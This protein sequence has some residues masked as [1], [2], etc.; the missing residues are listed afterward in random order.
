MR[1]TKTFIIQLL[2]VAAAVVFAGVTIPCFAQD[3]GEARVKQNDRDYETRSNV[4][5]TV[6]ESNPKPKTP[7]PPTPAEVMAQARDDYMGLQI[8]N[9]S[10]KQALASTNPL[11]LQ[12]ISSAVAEV[13]KRA[14]RLNVNLTLPQPKKDAQHISIIPAKTEA[15]LRSTLTSLS[16]VIRS[17]IANPAFRGSALTEDEQTMKAK[18]DLLDIIALSKQLQKD[19]DKLA[20]ADKKNP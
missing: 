12:F 17:F 11:D 8:Q 1:S 16:T 3:R 18:V 2:M 19:A 15:E 6:S 10:I 14:E 4:L 9:K 13:E 5:R 20:K 7:P